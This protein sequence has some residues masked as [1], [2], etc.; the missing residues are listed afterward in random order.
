VASNLK[1]KENSHAHQQIRTI[2]CRRYRHRGAIGNDPGLRAITINADHA[3]VRA[4]TI[5][6]DRADVRD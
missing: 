3:D 6:A 4:I 5:N 2:V 1:G